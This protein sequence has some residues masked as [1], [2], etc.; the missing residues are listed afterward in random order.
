VVD[1]R[2]VADYLDGLGTIPTSSPRPF[3]HPVR[4]RAGVTV[5]ARHPADHDWHCGVGLAVPDVNGTSFWGGGTYVHGTGYVLLDDHGRVVGEAPGPAGDGFR[6][7]LAW[8]GHD[9]SV[10]LREERAVRWAGLDERTWRLT[11]ASILRAERDVVLSSPGSKGRPGGGYGGFFW[12]LPECRD[13]EVFTHDRRGEDDVHGHI[14]PW[15]AWSSDFSAGPGESGP[16]TVVVA[17][18]TAAAAG[19]PWFVRLRDYPG[20]GSALAWTEPVSLA[21]GDTLERRWDLG[22]ADG[23]LSPAE[24]AALADVLLGDAG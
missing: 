10:L 24:A 23:R 7:R 4:T 5:T 18:A 9:G 12:R 13:A 11:F 19:E 15:V 3:L 17:S 21:A 22:V 2:E 20:V 1:G 8:V 16:A 14:A 6:Q